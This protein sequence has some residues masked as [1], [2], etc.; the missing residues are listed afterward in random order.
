MY[1]YEKKVLFSDIDK[2]S[3]MTI[4]AILNCMQDCININSESI[5]KGI[6][7]IQTSGKA[8][9]AIGWNIRINRFPRMFEDIVVK[10][11]PYGFKP[12]IGL[13][14]VIISDCEGN[15]IVCAD[16]FWGL[17]DVNTGKPVR[18]E[19]SDSSGYE[20]EPRYPM[21][22]CGRKIKL[23]ED[24]CFVEQRKV[25]HA[26]IDYNKHMSNSVYIQFANEYLEEGDIVRQI[27]VEYKN[28]T[29]YGELLNLYIAKQTADKRYVIKIE[30]DEEKDIKAVVEFMVL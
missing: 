13:R 17:V 30:G 14:N 25:R 20:L 26:Y 21:E 23:P 1:T 11:W 7:Y 3:D 2:N 16:S 10:T 5:G 9:F 29:R 12:S 6:D 15:D 28:Q 18:I 27:R 19:E 22:D 4:E 24:F 8:W